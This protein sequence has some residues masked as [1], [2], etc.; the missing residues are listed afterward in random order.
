MLDQ[1]RCLEG[2]EKDELALEGI[3]TQLNIGANLLQPAAY[4]HVRM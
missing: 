1:R 2:G 3:R 4:G